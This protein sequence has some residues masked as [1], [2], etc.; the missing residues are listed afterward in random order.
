MPLDF[1]M[2][3]FPKLE[4]DQNDVSGS[5]NFWKAEFEL[6]VEIVTMRL[7]K[8][9]KGDDVFQGRVKLLALLLS[10][11]NNEREALRSVG[12]DMSDR[13]SSYEQ[14]MQHLQSIYGKEDSFYLKILRLVTASQENGESEHSYLLRVEKLSRKVNFG[15]S[16]QAREEFALTIALKG[17]NDSSLR[18][19]LVQKPDLSWKLLRDTILARKLSSERV[20]TL[21][22]RKSSASDEEIHSVSGRKYELKHT[23]MSNSSSKLYR[24]GTIYQRDHKDNWRQNSSDLYELSKKSST[25]SKRDDNFKNKY[26]CLN[27]DEKCF[28]CGEYSHKI[29]HC[30]QVRCYTCNLKGHTSVDCSK[31]TSKNF[32][33]Q[34]SV[35]IGHDKDYE[36]SCIN[37]NKSTKHERFD[38]EK[39]T[40]KV[41]KINKPSL[42]NTVKSEVTTDTPSSNKKL[43]QKQKDV[44][45]DV[46][47]NVILHDYS[48]SAIICDS[49]TS[50]KNQLGPL[51][52]SNKGSVFE[53]N[54]KQQVRLVSP[55]NSLIYLATPTKYEPLDMLSTEAIEPI[56][57][58]KIVKPI[59]SFVAKEIKETLTMFVSN[60]NILFR[61]AMLWKWFCVKQL[62]FRISLAFENIQMAAVNVY[63][64]FHSSILDRRRESLMIKFHKQ[65]KYKFSCGSSAQVIHW[66]SSTSSEGG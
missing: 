30:S 63:I 24:Q 18:A 23:T 46:C 55:N 59:S 64:L 58:N 38:L 3:E 65:L 12:F 22:R 53:E 34:D 54:V 8:S 11:G 25:S 62:P 27:K 32:Q 49:S 21:K 20:T 51:T 43:N 60:L 45:A 36:H 47:D 9:D 50:K 61:L 17:L 40:V 52:L 29:R 10:I 4:L 2:S 37:L 56:K 57:V 16:E 6:S 26:N 1:E 41:Q 7:G 66:Q 48:C 44:S 33:S 13:K 14:A 42:D 28:G 35:G 31:V 39:T 15:K 5:W 19:K